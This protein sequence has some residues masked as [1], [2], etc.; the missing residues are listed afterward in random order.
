MVCMNRENQCPQCKMTIPNKGGLA[1]HI[2][3]SSCWGS[4]VPILS[5][6]TKTIWKYYTAKKLRK[7]ESP[8]LLTPQELM[9]LMDDAG[10]AANDIGQKS[11]QYQLA[12][13]NDTGNYEV[14][15]CRFITAKENQNEKTTTHCKRVSIPQGTYH[16]V[17][18]AIRVTGIPR[19]TLRGRLES[20]AEKW[21]GWKII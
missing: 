5:E 6:D 15:N 4:S 14:G 16:S 8:F 19:S 7:G 17:R 12:R 13:H 2:K 11:H 20:N 9:R 3:G 1:H 18:E 21:N 10:I